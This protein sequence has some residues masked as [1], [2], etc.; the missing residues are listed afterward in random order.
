MITLAAARNAS[1]ENARMVV[2]GSDLR[3]ER[4]FDSVPTFSEAA[5]TVIAVKSGSRRD[6]GKSEKQ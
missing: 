4:R 6:S 2:E 5:A 1:L 3:S